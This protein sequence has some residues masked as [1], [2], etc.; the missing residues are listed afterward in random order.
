MSDL[1]LTAEQ[2]AMAR[3]AGAAF[4]DESSTHVEHPY[5]QQLMILGTGPQL[6]DLYRNVH[7][8][9]V[10]CVVKLR[11]ARYGWVTL[12]VG[13]RL[14]DVQFGWLGE[15]WVPCGPGGTVG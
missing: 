3:Q 5:G 4:T 6:G 7:T 15:H 12:R 2:W 14:T 13:D 1:E 11:Q 9:Q 10:G 8:G